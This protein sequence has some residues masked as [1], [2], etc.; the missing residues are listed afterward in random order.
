MNTPG[1]YFYVASNKPN[2]RPINQGKDCNWGSYI[3][4]KQ[5]AHE[6]SGTIIYIEDN[7]MVRTIFGDDTQSLNW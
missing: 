6:N 1:L 3:I 2:N 4:Y 7:F 5:T